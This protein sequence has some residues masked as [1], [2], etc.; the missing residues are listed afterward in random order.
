MFAFGITPQ[1]DIRRVYPLLIIFPGIYY[2]LYY[3]Y[4]SEVST[5][6]C[7]TQGMGGQSWLVDLPVLSNFLRNLQAH[8]IEI[9]Q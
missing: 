6:A 2:I 4:P 7:S 9:E 1:T 8:W 3:M 5:A